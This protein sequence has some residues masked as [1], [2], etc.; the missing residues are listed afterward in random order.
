MPSEH[1]TFSTV[2]ERFAWNLRIAR[3]KAALSQREL[4]ERMGRSQRR[5]AEWE[6]GKLC[7]RIDSIVRLAEA[8]EIEPGAL[9]RETRGL[10]SA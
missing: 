8:L 1:I 3:R 6:S 9:L 10:G 2:A 5:I 4:A 7:P